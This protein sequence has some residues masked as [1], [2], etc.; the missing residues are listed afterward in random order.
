VIYY[1]QTILKIKNQKLPLEIRRISGTESS[2][3]FKLQ[4]V[5][6]PEGK[7]IFRMQKCFKILHFD[8]PVRQDLTG[9]SFCILTFDF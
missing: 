4:R 5:K 3:F 2:Q 1:L 8:L 6:I 9:G 7:H